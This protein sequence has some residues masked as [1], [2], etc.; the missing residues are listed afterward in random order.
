MH[1]ALAGCE[2]KALAGT[3]YTASLDL[4]TPKDGNGYELTEDF[5][6]RF[7]INRGLWVSPILAPLQEH[8]RPG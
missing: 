8:T 3:S 2:E 1:T 7:S 4:R 5:S 6:H